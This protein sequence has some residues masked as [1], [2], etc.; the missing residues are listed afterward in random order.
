V[1]TEASGGRA[2]RGLAEKLKISTSGG[3]LRRRGKETQNNPIGGGRG[4]PGAENVFKK[5]G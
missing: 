5:E 1:N 4:A 3:I 2:P